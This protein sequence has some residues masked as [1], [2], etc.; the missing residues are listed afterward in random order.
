MIMITA[1]ED[2]GALVADVQQFGSLRAAAEVVLQ[3]LRGHLLA[4]MLT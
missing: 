4:L 1:L 2:D 3:A